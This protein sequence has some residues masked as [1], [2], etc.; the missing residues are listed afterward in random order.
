MFIYLAGRG[1]AKFRISEVY[2]KKFRL[3][4]NCFKNNNIHR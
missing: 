1:V 4:P 2:E 3:Y